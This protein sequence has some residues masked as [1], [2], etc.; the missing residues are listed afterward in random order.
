[1]MRGVRSTATA[2][3]DAEGNIEIESSRVKP[4]SE[5][6]IWYKIPIIRGIL[7]F[8]TMLVV[9][10]KTLLRS[11]EVYGAE[12]EPSK[13]DKWLSKKLKIDLM[14]IV[15]WFS[16]ILGVALAVGLF[17]F[18]PQVITSLIFKIPALQSA[19]TV[20][21]SIIEG[22]IRLLIFVGYV[23]SCSFIPDV[24]RVFMYHGA[25]HK[26]INAFEH[27]EEL[28]VENVKKY[29]RIHKRC[30]TTFLVLVMIISIIVLALASWLTVDIF[31]WTNNFGVKFAVR[32][33]LL[34]LIAGVSYEVLKLLALSDNIIVRILRWPGLQLQRIT[35]KEPDG[36]M[37]EVAI[38]AFKTVYDMDADENIPE[39]KFNIRK[40]YADARK[41]VLEILPESE[42]DESDVD[43]IFC[44]ATG[45]SRAEIKTLKL[46]D[47]N[48]LNKAL[49]YAEE[50]KT[51]RP[52]QYIFGHTDFYGC[53]IYVGEGVLIP[54]PETE[55]LAEQ[56]IKTADGKSVLDLCT[57]SGAIAVAVKT[58]SSATVTASDIS[59]EAIKYCNKNAAENKADICIVKSDLFDNLTAKFD[60]IVT[61]PPYIPTADVEQ[62]DKTV[63]DYEP[64]SA[65]DGGAD[66]LDFYRRIISAA[67]AHLS[68][69][70]ALIMEIGIGEADGVKALLA[71]ADFLNIEVVKDLE[72]IDRIIAARK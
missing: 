15:I 14:Q 65:L 58:K 33:V 22:A 47:E 57:G 3:R 19:H 44:E 50:R 31:G 23:A 38:A 52:L 20:V 45:K 68:K 11:S 2:V 40:S 63:K 60:I 69:D 28:T 7:N 66:G 29:S 4:T 32:I 43:W 10:T 72:G 36:K 27:D 67:P 64:L 49:K 48:E 59:D 12:L 54:R 42:F 6:S 34:P 24:R 1:M 18:L 9:G 30:G 35:T 5:K 8:V 37:M 71:A 25:E 16:V 17:V 62:L 26:T 61:N 46:I 56:V 21:F 70:G 13:F 51:G 55:L 53:K 39:R 41:K